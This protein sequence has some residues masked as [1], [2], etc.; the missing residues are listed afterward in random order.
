MSFLTRFLDESL[1]EQEDALHSVQL[2]LSHLLGARRS[3]ASFVHDYGLIK[4]SAESTGRN[5][6]QVVLQ[7]MYDNI[8]AYEPR[9]TAVS[10]RTLEKDTQQILHIILTGQIARRS[11]ILHLAFSMTLGWLRV[12][13]AQWED[14]RDA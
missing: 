4:Y 9:L 11:C 12:V 8:L 7:E 6:A 14:Q 1:Q 2:H 3:F 10:L 5:L 13:D